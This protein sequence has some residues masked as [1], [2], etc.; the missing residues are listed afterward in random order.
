MCILIK[1]HRFREIMV[2]QLNFDSFLFLKQNNYKEI[3]EIKGKWKHKPE[4]KSFLFIEI[5]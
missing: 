1:L 2:L 4:S 3:L 5:L